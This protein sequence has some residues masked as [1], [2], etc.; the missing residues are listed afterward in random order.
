MSCFGSSFR[1][2]TLERMKRFLEQLDLHQRFLQQERDVERDW[3]QVTSVCLTLQFPE[4]DSA[5]GM[6]QI[7]LV[8]REKSFFKL[9]R[10]NAFIYAADST[11]MADTKTASLSYGACSGPSIKF[12]F[13]Y[14]EDWAPGIYNLLIHDDDDDS[15]LVVDF[16]LDDDSQPT[17]S[18]VWRDNETE[19]V[20]VRFHLYTHGE[21]AGWPDKL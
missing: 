7:D 11:L 20:D 5:I 21:T 10:F 8:G 12:P 4:K 1:E 9:D 13:W 6:G 17:H 2:K 15:M 18:F 19:E 14:I 16:S 3:N